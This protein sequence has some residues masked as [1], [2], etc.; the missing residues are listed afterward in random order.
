MKNLIAIFMVL[1]WRVMFTMMLGRVCG[2]ISAGEVFEEA[3]WKSVYKVSNPKKALPRKPPTLGEFVV[4][5]AALGGYID[6]K[7]A[8]PPGVKVMWKGMGRMV[9]FAIAWE[10]FGR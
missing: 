6:R 9:D 7:N 4:M 10:A 1:A 8:D 3:E 2:E 5:I